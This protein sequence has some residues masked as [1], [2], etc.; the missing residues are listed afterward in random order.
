MLRP[1][2]LPPA[3]QLTLPRGLLTPRSGTKLSLQYLGPAIRRTDAYRSGTLARWRSAACNGLSFSFRSQIAR[4]F[5]THHGP[6]VCP[7]GAIRADPAL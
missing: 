7:P 2:C 4:Y 6:I 1:V 5:T 3:A